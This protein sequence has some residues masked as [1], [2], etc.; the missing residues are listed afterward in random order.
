MN[1]DIT[2]ILKN[3]QS[4]PTGHAQLVESNSDNEMTVAN[5][6]KGLK[7]VEFLNY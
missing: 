4:A 1:S 5:V 3:A 7:I 2:E 6:V